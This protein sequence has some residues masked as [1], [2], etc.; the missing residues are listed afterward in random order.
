[1]SRM[2]RCIEG[3]VFDAEQSDKC[4][5][6]GWTA[7]P[8][9]AD[10]DQQAQVKPAASLG[11]S[12][13]AVF[14][15]LIALTDSLLRA[16]GLPTNRGTSTAVVGAVAILL[17][18]SLGYA[19][20]GSI[21]WPSSRSGA[22]SPEKLPKPDERPAVNLTPDTHSNVRPDTQHNASPVIPS[23]A[24]APAPAPNQA[25]PPPQSAHRDDQFEVGGENKSGFGAI[26]YSS[27]TRNW[28][29]SF[30]YSSRNA[31]ERRAIKKCG[32]SDCQLVASFYR[33][34][35]A[36]VDDENGVFGS[37]L[38]P[39]PQLALHDAFAACEARNGKNCEI[40]RVTCAR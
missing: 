37:G 16:V 28:G 2:V 23:P 24:P 40:E 10:Q 7:P 38:G 17:C 6:C 33:Q 20:P 36:V 21:F 5:T 32:Q 25:Q 29:E 15:S 39:A 34:C 8:K 22:P 31:S 35:G 19:L 11:Q 14:N 18:V 4:P 13:R 27:S 1:M 12:L 26:A 30:G 9:A 3:H